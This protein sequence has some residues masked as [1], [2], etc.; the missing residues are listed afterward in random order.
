MPS[1]IAT[2]R[3]P[4]SASQPFHTPLPRG[5]EG[6]EAREGTSDGDQ[7]SRRRD[8]RG[9]ERAKCATQVC[10]RADTAYLSPAHPSMNARV[11]AGPQPSCSPSSHSKISPSSAPPS[12]RR[13]LRAPESDL[14]STPE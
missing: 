1:R 7:T 10:A 13:S 11:D 12:W 8:A 9:F 5:G 2:T 4:T 14:Q 3:Q 6:C